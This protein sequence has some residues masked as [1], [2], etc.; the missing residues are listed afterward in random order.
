MCNHTLPSC[1]NAGGRLIVSQGLYVKC[2]HLVYD[3]MISYDKS[4]RFLNT[5]TVMCSILIS[6]S[7][8]FQSGLSAPIWLVLFYDK[9]KQNE[10]M[11]WLVFFSTE[12]NLVSSSVGWVFDFDS[13][14]QF[15]VFQTFQNQRTAGSGCLNEQI[16]I[17]Q[18][19]VPV[20]EIPLTTN[21][22]SCVSWKNKQRTSS[23]VGCYLTKLFQIV[24]GQQFYIRT[25]DFD[26][27]RAV[28]LNPKNRW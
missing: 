16:R 20:I 23:F 27:L 11:F 12:W 14:S 2:F 28:V 4:Y 7:L 13:N 5:F 8:C 26:F 25:G 1:F 17:E 9:H 15:L 18:P 3:H 21:D 6:Y 10:R 24:W 22:H 19:L